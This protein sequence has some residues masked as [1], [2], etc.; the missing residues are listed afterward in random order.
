MSTSQ[1]TLVSNLLQP[2]WLGKIDWSHG[3]PT[4]PQKYKE[5][6]NKIFDYWGEFKSPIWDDMY[7]YRKLF[8]TSNY[9]IF[10]NY[11]NNS[12]L[13]DKDNQFITI[14]KNKKTI[15]HFNSPNQ[16]RNFANKFPSN[17]GNG[18][19]S[20]IS[21]TENTD[22]YNNDAN[23]VNYNSNVKHNYDC[24]EDNF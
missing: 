17:H 14:S 10:D 6:Q 18:I 16:L 13:Q 9:N 1:E 24:D 12:N 11:E 20:E 2:S 19:D 3:I 5:A 23:D 22:F 4:S 15:K 7:E 8:S 21:D